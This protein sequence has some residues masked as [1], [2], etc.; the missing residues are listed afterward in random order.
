MNVAI[1][2]TTLL[3]GVGDWFETTGLRLGGALASVY[4]NNT[5]GGLIEAERKKFEEEYGVNPE[6]TNDPKLKAEWQNL[7]DYKLRHALPSE[8]LTGQTFSER[9]NSGQLLWGAF[10]AATNFA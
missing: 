3:P 5:R 10:D 1:P 9:D 6:T 4:V 7:I 2:G 8:I